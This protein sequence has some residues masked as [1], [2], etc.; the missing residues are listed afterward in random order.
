MTNSNIVVVPL[1]T[2]NA[3]TDTT[4]ALAALNAPNGTTVVFQASSTVV[5][6]INKELPVPPGVRVTGYGGRSEQAA[7]V[8]P[9]LQQAPGTALKCIMA[10]SGYLAG[11]YNTPQ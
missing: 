3:S 9:T 1:P 5:Y 8:M 10:S 7:G 6:V 2:G 4:N 11:L